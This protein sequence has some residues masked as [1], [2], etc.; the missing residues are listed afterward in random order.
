M[1]LEFEINKKPVPQARPRFYVRHHG[2]KHFVGAYDPAKC[3]T[4]KEFVAWHAKIIAVKKGLREPVKGP[5]AISLT[6]RMGEN[7]KEGFHT[8][9]PD[10]D[11]LAKAVK[12]ALKGVIYADDSQIVEAHLFKRYGEPQVKVQIKSL[13]V[14]RVD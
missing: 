8:K 13:E 2:L 12:D 10:L 9:R 4:Y 3:K 11:N 14:K 7:G 5:I 6:F 1:L